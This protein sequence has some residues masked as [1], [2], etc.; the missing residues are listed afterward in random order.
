METTLTISLPESV[1]QT[2]NLEANEIVSN[3]R[4]EY[5]FKLYKAGKLTLAQAAE[6]CAV[7]R[8]EFISLLTLS[9]I[10]VIDYSVEDLEDELNQISDKVL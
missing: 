2:M 4:K 7:S 3:M 10:P 1:L 5:S 9:A 8:Y 6:L